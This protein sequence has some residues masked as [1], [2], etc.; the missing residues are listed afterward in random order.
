M[1]QTRNNT[2]IGVSL[3]LLTLSG[4]SLISGD[5]FDN[6]LP[7]ITANYSCI[8]TCY[9]WENQ[10]R[11]VNFIASQKSEQEIIMSFSSNFIENIEEI[12]RDIQST[13]DEI[14]WD[15]I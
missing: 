4:S 1:N 8:N 10:F 15:L 12:D 2:N 5:F 14:F 7:T 11:N 6:S 9:N 3:V 13:I